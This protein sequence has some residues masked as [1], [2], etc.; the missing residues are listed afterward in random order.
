[1]KV[2]SEIKYKGYKIYRNQWDEYCVCYSDGGMVSSRAGFETMKKAKTFIDKIGEIGG[3]PIIEQRR[4]VED[5]AEQM[6][7]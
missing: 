6:R 7:K 4:A 3:I 5:L 1:M 2:D